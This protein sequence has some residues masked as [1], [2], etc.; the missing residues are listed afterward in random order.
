VSA[1]VVQ[2]AFPEAVAAAPVAQAPPPAESG[3]FNFAK[4]RNLKFRVPRAEA[5]VEAPARDEGDAIPI[6]GLGDDAAV[7]FAPGGGAL[8]GE[9]IVG[10][11]TAGE[12]ITIYPI[13]S[14]LL[15]QFENEPERWLDVRWDL[16]DNRR[17]RFP[18]RLSI[19]AI[20]E[21]GVLAQIAAIIA[22]HDGNIDNVRMSRRSQDFTEI[23]I[24][25][26]VFDLKHLTSITQQLRARP[27]VSR[28]ERVSA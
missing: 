8:P 9:R 23:I 10:I 16:A 1:D 15:A 22:E 20:N 2:A 6:R 4:I 28:A 27:V 14:P 18:T 19:L 3:W 24:D 12:G 13:H 21:P 11:M 26:E 5:P 7:R 17:R 25:L